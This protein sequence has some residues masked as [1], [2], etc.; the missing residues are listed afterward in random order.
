MQWYY[1]ETETRHYCKNSKT[2][3]ESKC[4]RWQYVNTNIHQPW[5]FKY[6]LVLFSLAFNWLSPSDFKQLLVEL[7][8]SEKPIEKCREYTD[9]L[10]S[11]QEFIDLRRNPDSS[12][13]LKARLNKTKAY[14]K[15]HGWW[16]FVFTYTW[17]IASDISEH[18][19]SISTSSSIFLGW[20]E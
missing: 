8:G 12:P 19:D 2:N 11:C 13:Q 10:K 5:F 18:T 3:I 4:W 9:D 7:K 6:A 20:R 14:L 16:I 17:D 1:G 15:N